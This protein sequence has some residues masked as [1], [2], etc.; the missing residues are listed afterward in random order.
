MAGPFNPGMAYNPGT[1]FNHNATGINDNHGRDL[2]Q[3]QLR[4]TMIATLCITC[5]LLILIVLLFQFKRTSHENAQVAREEQLLRVRER[6]AMESAAAEAR[7]V[8]EDR[9][10]TLMMLEG[11]IPE[12]LRTDRAYAA[13]PRR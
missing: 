6:Y 12:H 9:A 1:L 5:G 3:S 13:F 10:R 8:D 11:Y 2:S 7:G 4:A